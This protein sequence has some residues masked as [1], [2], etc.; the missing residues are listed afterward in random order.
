[1]QTKQKQSA[2]LASGGHGQLLLVGKG[3][4]TIC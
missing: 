2:S 4:G 3:S 1:M